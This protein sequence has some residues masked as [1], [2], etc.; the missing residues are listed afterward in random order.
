MDLVEKGHVKPISPMT[1]FP[2]E[3]IVS[4]FRFLRAGTHIGKVVISNGTNSHVELPVQLP[5][6]PVREK[7]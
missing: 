3:D 7:Y 6:S 4:A 2:F 1:V 5:C